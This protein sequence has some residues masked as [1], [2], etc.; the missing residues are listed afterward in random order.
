MPRACAMRTI[1]FTGTM[2]PSAFDMWVI[3]TILVRGVSSFSN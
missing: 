2:V 3:A 1:S